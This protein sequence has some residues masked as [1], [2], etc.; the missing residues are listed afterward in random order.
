MTTDGMLHLLMPCAPCASS[1]PSYLPA[2]VDT[3]NTC[4]GLPDG[5]RCTL[6]GQLCTVATCQAN[7]CT[8]GDPQ[9]N[10]CEAFNAGCAISQCISSTGQCT[11]PNVSKSHLCVPHRVSLNRLCCCCMVNVHQLIALQ[12]CALTGIDQLRM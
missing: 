1:L 5:T 11:S 2:Q 7:T 3:T 4:D 8:A 9:A 12:A 6:P 10:I